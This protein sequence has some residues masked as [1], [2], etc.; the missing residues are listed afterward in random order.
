MKINRINFVNNEGGPTAAETETTQTV[1]QT[2][3]AEEAG[4]ESEERPA[5]KKKKWLSALGNAVFYLA[6]LLLVLWAVWFSQSSDPSKSIF[7]FRFYY[8]QTPSMEP[9]IPVGAAV[10]TRHTDPDQ[11]QVGDVITYYLEDTSIS[12][13]VVE[14]LPASDSSGL[15][16]FRTKGIANE[17][18]DPQLV[19]GDAVAG[20]VVLSIPNLGFVISWIGNH[21]LL[22][23]WLF[24]LVCVLCALLG[25]LVRSARKRRR[26]RARA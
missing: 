21:V 16:W 1:A 18:P 13:Q 4:A 10:F 14:V 3:G 12:H 9:E 23:I 8:I 7:G 22:T 5:A 19:R 11:I 24:V 2:R 15:P 17:E 20:V 25:R 6:M 26:G